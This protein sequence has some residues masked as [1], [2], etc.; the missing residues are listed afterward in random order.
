MRR[1]IAVLVIAT[2]LALTGCSSDPEPAAGQTVPAGPVGETVPAGPAGGGATG[3]GKAA[4]GGTATGNAGTDG[5]GGTNP[6]L[7]AHH[8]GDTVDAKIGDSVLEMT[9]IRVV[10]P[11]GAGAAGD[12][13]T[14]YI[15]F[16]IVA[17]GP[18]T[19]GDSWLTNISVG[20]E[21]GSYGYSPT[22]TTPQGPGLGNI[23]RWSPGRTAQG[24]TSFVVPAAAT[25]L[26]VQFSA[27]KQDGSNTTV[28]WLI[29]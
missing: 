21:K 2:S 20:N 18:G 26:R 5:N 17:K 11:K 14:L 8:I 23:D 12:S 29:P 7:V 13:R 10:D 3:T 24:F 4:T 15:E 27:K 9:A 16:K 19:I 25:I 28:V 6:N 1:N 22:T